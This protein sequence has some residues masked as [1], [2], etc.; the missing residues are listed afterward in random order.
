MIIYDKH[1]L[2]EIA[3][4]S[5]EMRTYVFRCTGG[6]EGIVASIWKNKIERAR[7]EHRNEFGHKGKITLEE[8]ENIED[9][10]RK[11]ISQK[12][13]D[14]ITNMAN[15]FACIKCGTIYP[16]EAGAEP[17]FTCDECLI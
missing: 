3:V 7:K 2:Y 15:S 17:G 8:R 4:V 10:P 12:M 5:R 1:I 16:E 9:I 11:V 14:E 13:Y 6:C